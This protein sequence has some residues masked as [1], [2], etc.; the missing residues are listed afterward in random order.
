MKAF[1]KLLAGALFI[2]IPIT[3]PAVNFEGTA[4]IEYRGYKHC[5]ELRNK[6]LRVVLCPEMGGRVLAYELNGKN[7]IY[8]DPKSDGALYSP[9]N[10]NPYADGGRF[11]IGPEQFIPQR[12]ALFVGRWEGAIIGIREA[13]MISQKDTSTGVQLIRHFR[14]DENSSRLYVTQTI[15]NISDDTKYYSHWSRTFVKGG[16]IS[17]TPLNP[18]S[19]F[20]KGYLIYASGIMDF[21]PADTL[22]VRVRNG[23]LEITGAP[24]RPKFVM[25]IADGWSAYIGLDDQLFIKKFPVYP[26]RIYGEMSA[27]NAVIWYNTEGRMCEIEPLGPLETIE[28]GEQVSF[29][30]T[31]YLF[32]FD[33]PENKMPD[34]GRIISIINNL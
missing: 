19:R 28:P 23:I 12:P 6:S 1:M 20:P 24:Q 29:T 31:W 11:D 26:G 17:M 7:I 21:R 5:I 2:L 25:D 22:N 18:R 27:A 14:L 8:S 32:D 34:Q 13:E 4:V 15:R 16:G 30:E 10:P 33:Y 9:D 3:L